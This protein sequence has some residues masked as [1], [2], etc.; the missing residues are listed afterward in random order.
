ME[1]SSWLNPLSEQLAMLHSLNHPHRRLTL[2]PVKAPVTPGADT[3]QVRTRVKRVMI[4]VNR[5]HIHRVGT[6]RPRNTKRAMLYKALFTLPARPLF[7]GTRQ[8][9]PVPRVLLTVI[10]A[11]TSTPTT[12]HSRASFASL[13]R[14]RRLA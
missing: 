9:P 7:A 11:C 4:F 3:G 2:T 1:S 12:L 5:H 8:L 6:A 14:P 13:R 10:H